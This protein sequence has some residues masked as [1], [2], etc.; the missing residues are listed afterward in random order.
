MGLKIE[1]HQDRNVFFLEF[2]DYQDTDAVEK[3]LIFLVEYWSTSAVFS[4][5][6]LMKE[7]ELV[8]ADN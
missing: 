6:I 3:T 7:I 2:S 5:E 1:K 8:V 4:I